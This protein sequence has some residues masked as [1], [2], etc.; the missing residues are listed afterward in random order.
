MLLQVHYL[1]LHLFTLELFRRYKA[2]LFVDSDMVVLREVDNLP[3]PPLAATI[4]L[5]PLERNRT[6]N[7]ARCHRP[8][9]RKREFF[10]RKSAIVDAL[11]PMSFEHEQ[12]CFSTSLILIDVARLPPIPVMLAR[13]DALFA[14]GVANASIFW[15]QGF[16]QVT[17]TAHSVCEL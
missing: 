7:D 16:I 9:G 1:K 14:D 4:L 15:E 10:H 8:G 13:V 11:R 12:K 5:N 3:T 6:H 2:V 17:Q